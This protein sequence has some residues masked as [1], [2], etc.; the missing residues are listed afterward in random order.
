MICSTFVAGQGQRAQG[1]DRGVE[2]N[3]GHPR[4]VSSFH[5]CATGPAKLPSA[6]LSCANS[7]SIEAAPGGGPAAPLGKNLPLRMP[8]LLLEGQVNPDIVVSEAWCMEGTLVSVTSQCLLWTLHGAWDRY[9]GCCWSKN[10]GEQGGCRGPAFEE[11]AAHRFCCRCND[12]LLLTVTA[13]S[14]AGVKSISL[15]Y[16]HV[17]SLRNPTFLDTSAYIILSL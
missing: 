17:Q 14:S 15:R 9:H 5:T 2:K 6:A 12:D 1:A 7:H 16:N 11:P 13:S 8:L 10:T 4:R 3:W